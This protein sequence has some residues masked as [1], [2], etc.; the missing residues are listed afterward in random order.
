MYQTCIKLTNTPIYHCD[1]RLFKTMGLL[2]NLK[3]RFNKA[4]FTI[5]P[6]KKLKTISKEF[7]DNFNLGLVFYK[8]KRIAEDTLTLK[9]LD[10]RTS[11]TMDRNSDVALLLKASMQVGKVED[12]FKSTYGVTVQVKNIEL[13]QLVPNSITLGQ[14]AR[15]EYE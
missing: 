15:G 11:Q 8:G 13:T 12:L 14:A 2:N 6:N 3:D 5:A 9:Q 4:E 10:E 1:N 7:A